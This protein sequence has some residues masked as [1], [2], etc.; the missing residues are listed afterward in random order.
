M[1][2]PPKL[3]GP[4]DQ[5]PATDVLCALRQQLTNARDSPLR[6]EALELQGV[7]AGHD[8]IE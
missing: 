6:R 5:Q 8:T 2:W 4:L 1:P 7:V 3:A